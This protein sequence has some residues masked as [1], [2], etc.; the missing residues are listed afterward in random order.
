MIS[1]ELVRSDDVINLHTTLS[2][3]DSQ[4]YSQEKMTL[5][6]D[7][8]SFLTS[9]DLGMNCGVEICLKNECPV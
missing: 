2:Y 6:F 5:Q 8:F 3:K 1:N 9:S 4:K 7:A